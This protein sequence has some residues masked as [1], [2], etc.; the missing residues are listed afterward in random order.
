[1]FRFDTSFFQTDDLS[2][3]TMLPGIEHVLRQLH[4][5]LLSRGFEGLVCNVVCVSAPDRPLGISAS[6][7]VPPYPDNEVVLTLEIRWDNE[8][9]VSAVAEIDYDNGLAEVI[10]NQAN[11]PLTPVG[12][13]PKATLVALVELLSTGSLRQLGNIESRLREFE[14]I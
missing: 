6:M 9:S 4:D 12:V 10:V 14:Q 7:S 11:Q 13:I 1:M 8:Q 5:T 2:I 3:G